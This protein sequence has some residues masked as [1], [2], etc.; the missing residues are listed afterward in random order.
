MNEQPD[1]IRILLIEDDEE[2]MILT[3]DQLREIKGR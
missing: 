1:I 3:R 2:D